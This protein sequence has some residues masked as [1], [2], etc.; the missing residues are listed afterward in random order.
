MS[1]KRPQIGKDKMTLEPLLHASPA[2]QLHVAAAMLAF[3]LGGFVLFRRKG[4]RLHRL[5]GR[6]WV[7]LMVA[8]CVTSFFIHTI[9]TF[10]IW[11]PIHLLSVGTLFSLGWAIWQVRRRNIASH[12]F[13]MQGTYLGALVIAGIFTFLPGRIM[14]EVLFGGPS[15]ETGV[16]TAAAIVAAGAFTAWRG[17]TRRPAGS[18]E[19]WRRT[20]L[21]AP[22]NGQRRG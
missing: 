13:T 12:R 20:A 15:P 11:S 17:V 21:P 22:Q 14:Y 4:D 3:V 7:G 1:I 10:G 8:V 16:V 6:I 19:G 5:G 2:I 18:T 9:R